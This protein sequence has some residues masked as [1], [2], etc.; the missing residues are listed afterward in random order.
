MDGD[1]SEC[2]KPLRIDSRF[3]LPQLAITDVARAKPAKFA[4]AACRASVD[5]RER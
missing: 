4:I 3:A 5:G 1:G 2:A